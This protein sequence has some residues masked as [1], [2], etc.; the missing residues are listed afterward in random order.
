MS[1]RCLYAYT[2]P[3]FNPPYISINEVDGGIE[4]TVR[5]CMEHGGQTGSIVLT[6]EQFNDL[7]ARN[8]APK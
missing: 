8:T 7:L 3:G 4:V 5:G 6:T 1:R 2:P